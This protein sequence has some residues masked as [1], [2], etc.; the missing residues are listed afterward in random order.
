MKSMLPNHLI[1][2]RFALLLLFLSG[3]FLPDQNFAAETKPNEP[4]PWLD[5]RVN[6]YTG[7]LFY[8]RTD[9]FIPTRGEIPLEIKFSYNSLKHQTDQGFGNGWSFNFGIY[10]KQVGENIVISREEGEEDAFTWDG[11][12]YLPPAGVY[13]VLTE[14]EPGKYLLRTKHGRKYYFEDDSHKRLTKVSDRN[15]N[16]TTLSY[17][18]GKPTTITDPSGRMLDLVWVGDHLSQLTDQNTSPGRVIAFAYDEAGNLLQVVRPLANTWSYAYGTNGMMNSLTDPRNS[19]VTISYDANDAVAGLYCAPVLYNKTF[20]YN[21][22]DNTT[23]VTHLVSGNPRNTIYTF[24]LNGKVTNILLPDGSN[25]YLSWDDQDNLIDYTNEAG[26]IAFFT[27]DPMGNQLSKTDFMGFTETY[28]YEPSYNQVTSY[29]NKNGAPV[30]YTYDGFG[31][32]ISMTDC[33]G[34]SETYSYYPDGKLQSVTNRRGYVTTYIYGIN[35]DLTQVTDPLSFFDVYT[36]D[37]VG[38][39]LTHT[40]KRGKITTYTYDQLNRRIGVTD[41]QG[42][43]SSYTYDANSNLVSETNQNSATTTYSYDPLNRL[44]SSTDANGKTS[45]QT[46]DAAGNK[47]TETNSKGCTTSYVYDSRDRKIKMTDPLNHSEQYVYDQAGSMISVLSKTGHTT[48]YQYDMQGRVIKIIWPDSFFD[49]F[50]YLPEG[51]KSG[52]TN[53]NG[54]LTTYNYD[55]Q[56]RLTLINYPLSISES[57]TYDQVGNVVTHSNKNTQVTTYTYDA[58][59]RLLTVTD[60][61]SAFQS[62]TYDGVGNIVSE[63]DKNGAVT[64]YTYDNINRKISTLFPM[65]FNEQYGYDGVGNMTSKTDK[66]GFTTSYTFDNLNRMTV[67]TSPLGLTETTTYDEV[68]N[69]LTYTDKNGN[70]TTYAYDCMNQNTSIINAL[71]FTENFTFKPDGK[72]ATRVDERGGTTIWGY[73]CCHPSFKTDP[74]G[75]TE[76]YGYDP[77]GNRISFTDRNGNITQNTFDL[78]NRVIQESLPLGNLV[79]ITRDGE[80]NILIRQDANNNIVHN[81]YSPRNELISII[82]PD[83]TTKNYT[84]DGNGNLLSASYTGGIGDNT[85]YNYDAL[86]RLTSE[87]TNFGPLFSKTINYNYDANDNLTMAGS[88]TGTV[89]YSYDADNRLVQITDQSGMVTSFELDNNGNQTAIHYPNGVTTYSV[90]D[91]LNRVITVTTTDMVPPPLSSPGEMKI[92][93]TGGKVLN[94]LFVTDY[95]VTNIIQPSSG[96]GLGVNEPVT[97]EITNFGMTISMEVMVSFSVNGIPM[98]PELLPMPVPPEGGTAIYMFMQ[99]ADLSLPGQEYMIQACVMAIGDANPPNDC[100]MKMVTNEGGGGGGS[101]FQSFTYG[102][103]QAGNKIFEQH[104]DGTTINYGYNLRNELISQVTLPAN[105]VV[106]YTYKPAG[107]RESKTMNGIPT[108]YV[109]D[110]RNILMSVGGSI[111]ISDDNGNRLSILGAGGDITTYQYGLDDELLQVNL[112]DGQEVKYKYSAIGVMIYREDNGTPTYFH[113]LGKTLLNEFNTAGVPVAIHNPGISISQGPLTGYNFYNGFGS[114]TLQMDAAKNILATC[115][116]DPFGVIST[117]SGAYLNS[118][119][120]FQFSLIDGISDLYHRVKG[121]FI[122]TFTDTSPNP[123][124]PVA[125]RAAAAAPEIA[126]GIPVKGPEPAIEKKKQKCCGVN[127]FEVQWSKPSGWYQGQMLELDIDIE[128]KAGDSFDPACCQYCQNVMTTWV[129]YWGPHAFDAETTAPMHD[130]NYSRG[131]IVGGK[132]VGSDDSDGNQSLSDPGFKTDDIPGFNPKAILLSPR[133]RIFYVFTAE[134]MVKE[135]CPSPCPTGSVV[136]KRGP[137]S[138]GAYGKEPRTYFGVPVTLK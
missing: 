69:P 10:Y 18:G 93:S 29:T 45:S 71:G 124:K 82:Y 126:K 63:T 133:D 8:Q 23:T 89:N 36:Y 25:V 16:T 38:N 9:L 77:V 117:S 119:V 92:K 24:D 3:F 132:V 100:M 116:I 27:Y 46:F 122:D 60:P 76:L 125:S 62:C 22:C 128:F 115:V 113:N 4:G 136:A 96:P 55:C 85:T 102:Y 134:Q 49:V 47:L 112:P 109:Y 53:K 111:Y 33:S 1:A 95:A 32:R 72:P 41:A 59:D 6:T 17:T 94:P 74:L 5:I 57:Y 110:E 83:L 56:G 101:V 78:M 14:Y 13:D 86:N 106:S 135:T 20:T 97:I 130:D 48:N 54:A 103:D 120:M 43:T 127:K 75:N 40:D 19:T 98:V 105:E 104:L 39:M 37:A 7:N 34:N 21:N 52:H 12:S 50:T 90:F 15:G 2:M 51:Q 70:T 58:M 137:H 114:T 138:A 64:S 31:N 99:T 28:T 121:W 79:I 30:T 26:N 84:Y 44:I 108:F 91:A 65:G 129:I 42:Y 61:T 81:S 80:G 123:Q 131:K 73:D 66:R 11:V 118:E 35:G 87:T 88:E 67:S 107:Q 68:G